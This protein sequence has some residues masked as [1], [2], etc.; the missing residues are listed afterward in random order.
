VVFG[1][2]GLSGEIRPVPNGE[3]RVRE[4]AT[5]G[6]ERVILP[7]GNAPKRK[8]GEIEIIAVDRLSEAIAAL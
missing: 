7:R 8:V 6:F 4:A 5:H 3:E 1:E 2:V